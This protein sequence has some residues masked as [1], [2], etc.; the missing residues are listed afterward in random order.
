MN[1]PLPPLPE[2]SIAHFSKGKV[3]FCLFVAARGLSGDIPGD[4]PE[5]LP[6][7]LDVDSDSDSDEDLE[8]LDVTFQPFINRRM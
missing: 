2:R 7:L 4:L 1:T 6:E 5:D 3:F 8:F